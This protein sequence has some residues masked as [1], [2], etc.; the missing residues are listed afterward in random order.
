MDVPVQYDREAIVHR[1]EF[2]LV[3]AELAQD[4]FR[5]LRRSLEHLVQIDRLYRRNVDC[6]HSYSCLKVNGCLSHHRLINYKNAERFQAGK[7]IFRAIV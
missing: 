7:F 3:I 6:F 4:A 5:R 2:L 1:R